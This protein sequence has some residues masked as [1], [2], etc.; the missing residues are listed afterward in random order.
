LKF[1]V[2]DTEKKSVA[3]HLIFPSLH[4]TKNG[5]WVKSVEFIIFVYSELCLKKVKKKLHS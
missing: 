3:T 4:I 1:N 5:S 2:I